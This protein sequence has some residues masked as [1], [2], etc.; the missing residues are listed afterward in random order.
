VE[1]DPLHQPGQRLRL[2]PATGSHDND[3]LG[4]LAFT[5]PAN[6]APISPTAVV[7]A[8]T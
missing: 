8:A 6:C 5:R 1:G 2:R 4:H 7:A 3:R